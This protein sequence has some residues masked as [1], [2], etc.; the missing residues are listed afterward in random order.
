MSRL[1]VLAALAALCAAPYARADQHAVGSMRLPLPAS[2]L[3]AA[4]GIHRVDPSTL[5]LDIVRLA[6]A[7]PDG[8]NA[9]ESAARAALSQAL[10]GGG[11]G[12]L[13]PLPLS[14]RAWQ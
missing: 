6:F 8:A 12:D 4:I 14:P 5:P 7:S 1:L 3:A 9:S 11:A 13:V 10:A 2:E